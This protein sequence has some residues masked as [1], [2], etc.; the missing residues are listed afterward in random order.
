MRLIEHVS[1]GAYT[2]SRKARQRASK[3]LARLSQ[4]EAYTFVLDGIPDTSELQTAV[5]NLIRGTKEQ[6][7]VTIG[8]SRVHPKDDFNRK[9]G[10]RIALA[11]LSMFTA[12]IDSFSYYGDEMRI[13][14]KVSAAGK[15]VGDF[16]LR[17]VEGKRPVLDGY[18]RPKHFA[19]RES[20][21]ET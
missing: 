4:E 3:G 17:L 14:F 15:H 8:V 5:I 11:N 12:E 9:T 6:Y 16:F 21:T 7:L 19:I 1:Y 18:S 10:L 2:P 13:K 20:K